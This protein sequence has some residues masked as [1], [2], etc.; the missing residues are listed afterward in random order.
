MEGAGSFLKI[1]KVQGGEQSWRQGDP[2][3]GCGRFQET[4]SKMP[5]GKSNSLQAQT[6]RPAQG[7]AVFGPGHHESTT[8]GSWVLGQSGSRKQCMTDRGKSE[9]Q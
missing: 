3:E 6:P 4:L 1:S 2:A 5:F 9:W 8:P 7:L